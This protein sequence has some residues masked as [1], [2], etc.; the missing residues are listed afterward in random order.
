MLEELIESQFVK[1]PEIK[2]SN[3]SESGVPNQSNVNLNITSIHNRKIGTPK[4][5]FVTTA[6]IRSVKVMLV[7]VLFYQQLHLQYL[8][9]KIVLLYKSIEIIH[10]RYFLP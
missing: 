3:K 2:R 7:R 1:G 6:S 10:Y 5:L 9:Y 4:N 8:K